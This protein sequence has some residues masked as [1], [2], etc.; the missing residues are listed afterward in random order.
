MHYKNIHQGNFSGKSK[1]FIHIQ[2]EIQ[3]LRCKTMFILSHLLS[4]CAYT[5]CALTLKST[6]SNQ[7]RIQ[8]SLHHSGIWR[9]LGRKSGT[10][11]ED[12][13]TDT[14]MTSEPEWNSQTM[15]TEHSVKALL[16]QRVE[17]SSCVIAG[18]YCSL[19]VS[20]SRLFCRCAEEVPLSPLNMV[21]WK[22]AVTPWE[23]EKKREKLNIFLLACFKTWNT[24]QLLILLI[25]ALWWP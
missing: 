4:P 24:F 21:A 12:G 23:R 14:L 10:K 18:H 22:L 15:L 20:W 8:I 1:K 13:D 2:Y 11:C 7:D 16:L 3:S 19:S 25:L 6:Q 5:V 17:V 9:K